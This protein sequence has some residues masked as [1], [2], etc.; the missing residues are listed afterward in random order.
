MNDA[1]TEICCKDLTHRRVVYDKTFTGQGF[2]STIPE[3]VTQFEKIILQLHLKLYGIGQGVR[4]PAAHC[5][6]V[7]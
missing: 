1:V 2:V 3:G 7:L 5:L 6:S 4:L